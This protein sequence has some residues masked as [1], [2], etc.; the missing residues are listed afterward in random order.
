MTTNPNTQPELTFEQMTQSEVHLAINWAQKEGWNP[1]VHDAECFYHADPTGFYAAKLGSEIVGTISLVKY[2][3]NFVFEGLYIVKPECRGKGIGLHIQNYA[4][5]LCRGMNL[6]IDGVV[7]M[8]E[9]YA[10][11]GLKL[12]YSNTR[13]A[14]TAQNTPTKRC[15]PI[16]KDDFSEVAAYDLECFRFD[17]SRFL[18]CWLYQKNA[19]SMLIRSQKTDAI[20]GYG[21]IR[22]C[23]EGY[24][25]GPLFAEN[26]AYANMLFD[27]L[28]STVCGETVFLDVPE[29]NVAA[30][31]LA[32]KY[33]MKPV[34]STLRMYNRKAPD[35][36]LNKIFG[37]TSF[38]LG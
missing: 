31:A 27:S 34:F 7:G 16:E 6:G 9:K 33:R 13:Y 19:S 23:M 20:S 21:V 28:T 3:G 10:H 24:K 1:G 30:V 17:R 26:P 18:E 4:L 35:L 36:P 14:G 15:F 29:P 22:K 2:P 8:R 12:A 11:K 25:I 38:E 32:E 37:I 5:N